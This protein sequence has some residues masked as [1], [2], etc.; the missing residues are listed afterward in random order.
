MHETKDQ[1]SSALKLSN[2]NVFLFSKSKLQLC[3]SESYG[4]Q[5]FILFNNSL[6]CFKFEKLSKIKIAQ[7]SSEHFKK[8]RAFS[9]FKFT[10]HQNRI[11]LSQ[12]LELYRERDRVVLASPPRKPK[13]CVLRL[14]CYYVLHQ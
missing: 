13:Q 9:L 11:D 6:P 12:L 4:F 8:F 2:K 3:V 10:Q 7:K 5:R 1:P 14:D